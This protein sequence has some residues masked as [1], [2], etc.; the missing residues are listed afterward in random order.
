MDPRIPTPA[1]V[2][3]HPQAR[4]VARAG[5][6]AWAAVIFTLS[7]QPG[8]T[9]PG[10]YGLLAHL[11]EYALLGSLLYASLRRSCGDRRAAALAVLLA[12][13]YAL[14]DEFHQY[15]VPQRTVDAADWG[16]DVIGA[17]LGALALMLP[18][19]EGAA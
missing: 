15:F 9:L 5:A 1:T 6:I 16:T 3:R 18:D 2:L 8:G 13:S 14:T 12:A 4:W 19:R 7:A 10:R 11:I 17:A